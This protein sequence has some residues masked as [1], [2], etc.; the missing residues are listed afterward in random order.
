LCMKKIL[1][2]FLTLSFF[3]QI[4]AQVTLVLGAE[5]STAEGTKDDDQIVAKTTILNNSSEKK[6]VLWERNVLSL[7][8][9]WE[10]SFCDKNVCYN[11]DIETFEFDLDSMEQAEI[12]VYGYPKGF[13]RAAVGIEG[14]TTVEIKLTDAS[15]ATNTVSAV[16]DVKSDGFTTTS[17]R[18]VAKPN[19]K[20]YPNPTSQYISLTNATD[21]NRLMVYNIVG[22]PVK[23]FWAN[24]N[25]QYDVANLPIGIYLVR[26]MD[27]YDHTIKTIRLR[28]NYP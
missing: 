24:T 4:S 12:S 3:L 27:K 18:F 13:D 19:I 2:L 5:S 11:P 6:T 1:L 8:E 28:V 21:V 26:L 25:N 20:I 10:T 9:G 23:T 7:S 16:F 22:R 17:T 15:D 14:A